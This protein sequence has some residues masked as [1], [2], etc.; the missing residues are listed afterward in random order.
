MQE[1]SPL[2]AAGAIAP[3]PGPLHFIDCNLPAHSSYSRNGKQD[4]KEKK[5]AKFYVTLPPDHGDAL[6][7]Y[8]KERDCANLSKYV[9]QCVDSYMAGNGFGDGQAHLEHEHRMQ[10]LKQKHIYEAAEEA[11]KLRA[12]QCA[13]QRAAE[14]ASLAESQLRTQ[15]VNMQ[16]KMSSLQQEFDAKL[17]PSGPALVLKRDDIESA[18]NGRLTYKCKDGT[19]NRGGAYIIIKGSGHVCGELVID[20][21]CKQV[22]EEPGYVWNLMEIQMY[23]ETLPYKVDRSGGKFVPLS[24][25]ECSGLPYLK[26]LQKRAERTD[27]QSA[28]EQPAAG[29][30]GCN[31]SHNCGSGHTGCNHSGNCGSGSGARARKAGGTTPKTQPRTSSSKQHPHRT[32]S[33]KGALEDAIND[34]IM[35]LEDLPKDTNKIAITQLVSSARELWT[36]CMQHYND[37]IDTETTSKKRPLAPGAE[38]HVSDSRRRER[39]APHEQVLKE[40]AAMAGESYDDLVIG[41][42][43]RRVVPQ[44]TILKNVDYLKS[45]K[46]KAAIVKDLKKARKALAKNNLQEIA[47]TLESICV[48]DSAYHRLRTECNLQD[49]LPALYSVKKNR[50]ELNKMLKEKLCFQELLGGGWIVQYEGVWDMVVQMLAEG[51][52]PE[53]HFPDDNLQG[54]FTFDG[55]AIGGREQTYIGLKFPWLSWGKV[56]SCKTIF[57][58]GIVP[59]KDNVE[60]L[61]AKFNAP[62]KSGVGKT[63]TQQLEAVGQGNEVEIEV[64]GITQLV[65]KQQIFVADQKSM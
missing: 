31:H 58:I 45:G 22:G 25:V 26:Y 12:F 35:I 50:I 38:N 13:A 36:G 49:E 8:L 47:R 23:P 52:F 40:M 62:A 61:K 51:M 21:V 17:G 32:P 15:L 53:S 34:A 37:T 42:Q 65:K 48:A 5:A 6:R 20:S 24:R 54:V 10:E 63:L 57:P 43:T 27:S 41:L 16:Q 46:I 64:A 11:D 59:G 9:A 44:A 4:Y 60:N 18:Q 56:Q 1:S 55:R 14:S 30:T 7:A 28:N 19:K 3:Q 2:A 29:H 33:M 39:V